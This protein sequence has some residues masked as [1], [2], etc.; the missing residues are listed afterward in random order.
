MILLNISEN[1][2]GINQYL[3][4]IKLIPRVVLNQFNC[5]VRI[6]LLGS[7]TENKFVII[8]RVFVFFEGLKKFL[9]GW[10]D[11]CGICEM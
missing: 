10:Y 8:V 11:E 4:G 3:N 2:V 9:G 6:E 7:N 1:R 5:S